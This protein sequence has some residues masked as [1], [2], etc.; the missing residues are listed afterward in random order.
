MITKEEL[1]FWGI[2]PEK[3]HKDIYRIEIDNDDAAIVIYMLK[4]KPVE[5]FLEVSQGLYEGT[6][7]KHLNISSSAELEML[8]NFVSKEGE[9]Y[10]NLIKR[11][12]NILKQL[13]FALE[14]YKGKSKKFV[15]ELHSEIEFYSRA[16]E[17]LKTIK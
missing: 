17:N 15:A 13:H 14:N 10:S 3:G 6:A 7:S 8:Y 5:C 16:L 1:E 9:F 12:E 2:K 11:C 4:N